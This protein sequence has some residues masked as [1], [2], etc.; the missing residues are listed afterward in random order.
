M[1]P[2][3]QRG[4]LYLWSGTFSSLNAAYSVWLGIMVHI[5]G[6]VQERCNSIANAP[7][8]RLSCANLSI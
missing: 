6:L 7:E 2:Q 1:S 8:L 5:D 4:H 3:W